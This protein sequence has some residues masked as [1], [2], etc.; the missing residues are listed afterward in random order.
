MRWFALVNWDRLRKVLCLAARAAVPA[1]MPIFDCGL[2]AEDLVGQTLVEFFRSPNA[3]GFSP[4]KGEL[5]STEDVQKSLERFLIVVL[6]RRAIDH[7]RRQKHVAGS[8]D[9]RGSL[10][11]PSREEAAFAGVE[12]ASA[13]QK[14]YGLLEGQDD[15]KDLVA[16][17]E[18][19]TGSH[20]VNQEL[21][22]ILNKTPDE[23]VNLKRRL[24]QYKPAVKELLY[25]EER[26]G[27][28]E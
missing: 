4:P 18:L 1:V 15:L 11:E 14:I 8:L 20:N 13:S 16:A 26:V 22:N 19:T 3:L 28:K 21:A 12:Y 27:K 5:T 24:L 2:D 9:D 25:G 6:K 23:V 17:A 7:L 10:P